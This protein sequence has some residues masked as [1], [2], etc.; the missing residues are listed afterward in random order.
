[1][2]KILV[3]EDDLQLSTFICDEL[4]MRHHVISAIHDGAEASEHLRFYKYD[5]II[6]DWNLPGM[7]GVEICRIFREKGGKTPV[8]MLTGKSA[9]KEKEHGLDC[10][11]DDYLTKPFEMTEVAARVRALLR[12]PAGYVPNVLQAGDIE[13]DVAS[14]RVTKGDVEIKLQPKEFALLEFLMRNRN[15]Y[16]TAEALLDR[17]WKTESESTPESLRTCM[18]RLREKIDTEGQPSIIT[19]IRNVGY[20]IEE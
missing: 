20:R 13:L 7:D 3:I 14:F 8:L 1:M 19:N 6:L 10:G 2:A 17:V 11:A 12:R 15:Q 5:L 16:F 4:K 18:K 9:A